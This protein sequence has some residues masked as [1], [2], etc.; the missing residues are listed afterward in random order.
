MAEKIRSSLDPVEASPDDARAFVALEALL[1]ESHRWEDLVR[2][3]EK[4]ARA[5]GNIAAELLAKAAEV[6]RRRLKNRA[7]AEELYRLLLQ[8][9]P[10]NTAAL[11][12]LVEITEEKGDAQGLADV[13]ERQADGAANPAEAARLYLR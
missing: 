4:Q 11:S 12:S 7:R 9:D 1:P 2:L 10:R 6:A 8:N 13:L 3:Y 5:P